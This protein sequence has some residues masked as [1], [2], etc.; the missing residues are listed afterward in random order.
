MEDDAVVASTSCVWLGGLLRRHSD[1]R[2][3]ALKRTKVPLD[4]EA[5]LLA[6][7]PPVDDEETQITSFSASS[8]EVQLS[9]GGCG[10]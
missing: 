4:C 5:H 6:G 9:F 1:L 2:V 7:W 8:V 3:L 10:S